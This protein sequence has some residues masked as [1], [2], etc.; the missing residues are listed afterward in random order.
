MFKSL[1]LENHRLNC[2]KID[3]ICHA[4]NFLEDKQKILKKITEDLL[5]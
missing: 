3:C 1:T 2:E 5:E 4:K